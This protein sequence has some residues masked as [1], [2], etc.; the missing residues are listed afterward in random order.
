MTT[1]TKQADLRIGDFTSNSAAQAMTLIGY[2]D[3]VN[4]SIPFRNLDF[5]CRCESFNDMIKCLQLIHSYNEFDSDLIAPMAKT[6][7]NKG[8]FYNDNNPNNGNDLFT[9]DVAR[10]GSP[11]LYVSLS[12]V[13]SQISLVDGKQYNAAQFNAD[14]EAFSQ[15]CRCDEFNI[16]K[17]YTLVARFWWD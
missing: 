12:L 8:V 14:M 11:A 6:F 1:T 15:A 5:K 13:R 7:L 4:A 17:G 9:F 16:E 10:E 2:G 3:C